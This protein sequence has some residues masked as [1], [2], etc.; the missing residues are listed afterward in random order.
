ML[1]TGELATAL[2]LATEDTDA[3]RELCAE[4]ARRVR[5]GAMSAKHLPESYDP[6]TYVIPG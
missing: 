1:T 2:K 6:C 5:A 3:W 4:A